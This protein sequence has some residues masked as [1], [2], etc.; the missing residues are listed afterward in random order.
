MRYTLSS[1]RFFQKLSV[2]NSNCNLLRPGGLVTMT[3][4]KE[5]LYKKFVKIYFCNILNRCFDKK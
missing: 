2:I 5:V 3:M 1:I 4:D